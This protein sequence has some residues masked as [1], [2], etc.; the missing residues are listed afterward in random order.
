M[1]TTMTRAGRTYLLLLAWLLF[2][3]A[4]CAD[5]FDLS[6]DIMHGG[7]LYESIAADEI[8]D[9]H[10]NMQVSNHVGPVAQIIP[11]LFLDREFRLPRVNAS[12]TMPVY[13][14]TSVFRL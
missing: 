5:V 11:T 1:F 6:D 9:Q 13:L 4:D 10:Q 2:T 7:A 12:P 14:L 8:E 3:A